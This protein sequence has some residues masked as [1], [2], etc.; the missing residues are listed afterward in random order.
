MRV[1]L[2]ERI[3]KENEL[4]ARKRTASVE[5]IVRT[6]GLILEPAL[7]ER[8]KRIVEAR[9]R[10]IRDAFE[11]KRLLKEAVATGGLALAQEAALRASNLIEAEYRALLG[12]SVAEKKR[13]AITFESETLQAITAREVIKSAAEAQAAE[14]RFHKIARKSKQL[15]EREVL[16]PPVTPSHTSAPLVVQPPKPS[17]P[18]RPA[19]KPILS[20]ASV[21][22]PRDTKPKMEDVKVVRMVAGPIDELA[23][24]SIVEF[25]RLSRDP[26]EATLKIRD[27]IELL[28]EEGFER[29]LAAVRAWQSSEPNRAYLALTREALG[30]STTVPDLIREKSQA[31]QATLTLDE[32]HAILTLNGQL[33][34]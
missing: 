22:L 11:T 5:N 4:T 14:D 3:P 33:Q 7:T 27:K 17:A 18:P 23:T 1:E 24:M 15:E 10:D 34:L 6:S 30:A 9:L 19:L 21:A 31:A 25:R 16:L 20:P 8:F 12:Q 28:K 29:Y 13:E 26:R 32:F 2:A